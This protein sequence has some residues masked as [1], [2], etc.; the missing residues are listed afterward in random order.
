MVISDIAHF[1][2][3]LILIK[4]QACVG[5]TDPIPILGANTGYLCVMELNCPEFLILFRF[6]HAQSLH[7][8]KRT[9][10]LADLESQVTQIGIG[11]KMF[12]EI[13]KCK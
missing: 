11:R 3:N 8:T 2:H 5:D 13:C 4:I 12:T 7:L 6:N 1:L 9:Q 10:T